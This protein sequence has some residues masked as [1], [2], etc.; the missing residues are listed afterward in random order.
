MVTLDTSY[1]KDKDFLLKRLKEQQDFMNDRVDQYAKGKIPF[2]RYI[3]SMES[4]EGVKRRIEKDLGK[5]GI[6]PQ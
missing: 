3:E 6:N 2:W 4:A 1:L 5:L